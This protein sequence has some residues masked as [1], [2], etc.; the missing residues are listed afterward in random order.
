MAD[1]FDYVIVGAGSAG[2]ILANRLSADGKHSVCVL[3]AGPSDWNPYIHVPAGFIKNLTNP[4]INWMYQTESIPSIGGRKIAMP[5]GKTLGGSSSINGMIYN[6][7]QRMDFDTWA[8][9]G[10]RGWGYSD[11][12]PYFKRTESRQGDADDKFRGRDG[13]MTVETISYTHPL[14]DAF[15]KGAAEIGIP[16]NPDYNGERQEGLNYVQRN[17]RGRRRVST[18]RAYLH[19]AKSRS[20]L[21][22]ITRA[23]ATKILLEGKKAVGIEYT[24]GGKGGSSQQVKAGKEVILAG[25]TINSPQLLQLSGIGPAGLLKDLGIEVK[26]EL[27]GVGENLRDHF[28]PRMTVRAKDIET[29]NER[30]HGIRRTWE[31]AKYLAGAKSI[32]NLNPSMVYGFW[33]SDPASKSNDLQFIFTPASYDEGKH[34]VLAKWAGYTIAC[35]QHRPESTGYVRA[36]S[37]DPFDKPAINPNYL[38]HERDRELIVEAM[39][40]ARRLATTQAMMPYYD[41]E[42]LPGG[43][44][45]TDAELLEAAKETG[46]TTYHPNGTC[47][48][49]PATD[50]G[51]VVSD[52]LKVHGMQGLRVVDA[53]IMPQMLSAN[54]NACTMMIGEKGSDMILG[55]ALLEPILV[56]EL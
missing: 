39:K 12:L 35:W 3:E 24:K 47:K 43:Q 33:H 48:M 50:P 32:V 46:S 37:A 17:V 22:V 42:E 5:R 49:G 28:A 55:K 44:Y 36:K 21:T 30:A 8:Q 27:A 14:A 34:G 9:Q 51:A 56:P 26:H 53:S 16:R 15:I 31:V 13:G 19:P 2:C 1:T 6:R 18:A 7:G 52:E 38:S 11:V 23:H 54:L 41:G 25:G 45:Q 20:N 4:S 40:L 10:N 29:L